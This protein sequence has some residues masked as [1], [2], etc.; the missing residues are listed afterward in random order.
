ME[1]NR[2][3]LENFL[4]Y[5]DAELIFKSSSEIEGKHIYLI[6]GE[7][8][9][10]KTSLFKA[11]NWVLYGENNRNKRF[12]LVNEFTA[13]VGGTTKIELDFTHTGH[14]YSLTR[15]IE[16][17]E[18]TNE[19]TSLSEQV[20]LLIDGEPYQEKSIK[21]IDQ[22]IESLLPNSASQFYFFDG[23]QI[24]QYANDDTGEDVKDAIKV[25]L[26]LDICSTTITDLD[27]TIKDIRN[28]LSKELEKEKKFKDY[29]IKHSEAVEERETIQE[30]LKSYRVKLKESKRRRDEIWDELQQCKEMDEINEEINQC[31]QE[32]IKKKFEIQQLE[33]DEKKLL[34]KTF[35]LV[36][37]SQ[38]KKVQ[39]IID[40]TGRKVE[41][42]WETISRTK[43]KMELIRD[44]LDHDL[45]C[46]CG[47]CIN[48]TK[49]EKLLEVQSGL[50]FSEDEYN[51]VM[52]N[53][54]RVKELTDKVAKAIENTEQTKDTYHTI[55]T[56]LTKAIHEKKSLDKKLI[57][58][59]EEQR[60]SGIAS[61]ELLAERLKEEEDEI[62]ILTINIT[63][64]E[65]ELKTIDATL[66]TIENE[67]K[68]YAG[69]NSVIP[70]LAV[71]LN[72]AEKLK[73]AFEDYMNE[74]VNFKKAGIQQKAN[75]IYQ[76]T[77]NAPLG[78]LS[79][80]FNDDYTFSLISISGKTPLRR[81]SPGGKQ[82]AAFSFIMGLNTYASHVAPVVFDTPTGHLDDHHRIRI[83]NE[84]TKYDRGQVFMFMTTADLKSG[85]A[86]QLKSFV[87]QEFEIN[88]DEN[89]RL[90][91]IKER[92]YS[93]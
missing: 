79:I 93:V 63:K 36:F 15:F 88:R 4:P 30:T 10:G 35:L 31:N 2:L 12:D 89:S 32:I 38:F 70:D 6:H 42:D 29:T 56:R 71:Q 65:T 53:K 61:V 74:V 81:E 5:Q 17:P 1:I 57:T 75:E 90:S 82:V 9:F 58:L 40:E 50:A 80:E 64:A 67:A 22:F 27:S 59:K 47:D 20:N 62:E 60:K 77:V 28:T 8:R 26:G 39:S 87:A 25:F 55:N 52:S 49:R 46:I 23:A 83:A 48:N 68:N 73:S 41:N 16:V 72:V 66:S 14:D 43:G 3:K 76:R 45:S 51:K 11:L 7:N 21:T 54:V 19:R 13:K 91:V 24:E 85:V 18:G 78:S 44:I 92:V 37:E 69:A 86:E 34:S 84:L 33:E